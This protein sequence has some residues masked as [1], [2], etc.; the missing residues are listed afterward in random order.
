[1]KKILSVL[2]L[3]AAFAGVGFAQSS[4]QIKIGKMELTVPSGWMAQKTDETT[5][6]VILAPTVGDEEI[7]ANVNLVT[8]KLEGKITVKQYLALTQETL[9]EL[10]DSFEILETGSNYHI[11]YGS[12]GGVEV[13]QLQTFYIKANVIYVLTFTAAPD[14]FY[15]YYLNDF[16]NMSKSFK[17]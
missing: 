17:Y 15:E 10:Y 14:L 8:D 2:I 11:I 13:T 6:F 4:M 3:L 12:I 9:A 16:M 1:M 5:E 7:Q